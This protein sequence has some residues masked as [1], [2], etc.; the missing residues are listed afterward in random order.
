MASAS[1][2]ARA[3]LLSIQ[4]RFAQAIVDGTKTV[5]LRRVRPT[6]SAGDRLVFYETSPTRA[7]VAIATVVGVL[8]KDPATLRRRVAAKSGLQGEEFLAYFSGCDI[9]FGIEFCEV[10]ALRSPVTLN[11]LRRRVPG[12]TPPQ[13]YHYLRAGTAVHRIVDAA[14]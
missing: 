13:S 12:F 14:V 4:P 10:V 7:V 8:A 9:G 2:S 11:D 1:S 3:L 5:E 6:V